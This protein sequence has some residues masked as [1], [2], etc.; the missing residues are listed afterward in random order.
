MPG[1]ALLATATG[2]EGTDRKK[3]TAAMLLATTAAAPV[4]TLSLLVSVFTALLLLSNQRPIPR[5]IDNAAERMQY[6]QNVCRMNVRRERRKMEI[7]A[8]HVPKKRINRW[9]SLELVLSLSSNN[10]M[11][12]YA[13][14]PKR[15]RGTS[16]PPPK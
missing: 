5:V 8:M 3:A 2:M 9:L 10:V 4:V 6:G 15:G 13:K 12:E 7:V 14:N 11:A 1:G 16:T